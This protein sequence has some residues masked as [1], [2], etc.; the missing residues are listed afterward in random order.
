MNSRA[1][2]FPVEGPRWYRQRWPWFLIAGPFAVVVAS[3]ASAW[4]A[5][6]SDDGVVAQDYYKQGL[7]INRKLARGTEASQHSPGA[8]ISV[9]G[10]RRIHVQLHDT[11]A[12]PSRLLLTLVR[13]GERSETQHVQLAPSGDGEWV[14]TM[15]ALSPGRW[16]VELES[17]SWRLPVTIVAGPFTELELGRPAGHP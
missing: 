17:E 12:A 4:I 3:L 7:L 5:A 1:S 11:P 8:S 6:S 10:D 15:P 2:S 16:I 14:A 13:P 9:A